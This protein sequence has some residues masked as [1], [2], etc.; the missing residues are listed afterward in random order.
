MDRI[1]M[2]SGSPASA[3]RT[4]TVLNYIGKQFEKR[5]V[6]VS[7]Y[8]V[9]DLPP[10]QFFQPD[11]RGEPLHGMLE[12]LSEADG[13]VIAS[14]VYNLFMTGIL[15]ALLD[16]LPRDVF[17]GKPVLPLM[18]G[19]TEKHFMALDFALKPVLAFMKGKPLPGVYL[20][21]RKVDKQAENPLPDPDI[22][23]RIERQMDEMFQMIK[24]K[25]CK[26]M[27]GS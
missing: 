16:L 10:G 18:I 4:D 6:R 27:K 12:A 2:I 26:D 5:G 3:S 17:G 25:R 1:V 8:S 19:G 7:T 20:L 24:D 23:R 13:Y 15:K 14:P 11:Y 21:D 22:Q 9:R